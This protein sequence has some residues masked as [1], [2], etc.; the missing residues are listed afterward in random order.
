MMVKRTLGTGRWDKILKR[1]M[2]EL[3]DANNYNEAKEEWLATG[4]VWWAGNGEVPDWVSN[5]SNGIGNCLCGHNVVYH[6]EIVNTEN[7]VVECVG[8][9]HINSY[10]I[11]RQIAEDLNVE[12]DTITDA[13]VQEWIKVR[14]GS[15]KEE[16]WW[17]EN[18]DNFRLMFNKIKELDLHENVYLGDLYWSAKHSRHL[19]KKT[20]RKKGKGNFGSPTYRMASIVWRWNH[21]DN[22]KAQ[23]NTTGIPSDKVMQDLALL[24]VLSDAKIAVM[25][26]EKAEL[27]QAEAETTL[28][29]EREKEE[30]RIRR[31]ERAEKQRIADEKWESERPAREAARAI[32]AEK[33]RVIQEERKRITRNQNILFLHS[34][35]TEEFINKCG[36]YNIPVFGVDHAGND[37]EID[38]LVSI[39]RLFESKGTLSHNQAVSLRDIMN[40]APTEK[41]INYLRDLGYDG[42]IPTK[43]FASRKIKEIKENDEK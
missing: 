20:L 33:E 28:R 30:Y 23:T 17:A 24:F 36:L 18:G 11:M 25:E 10:L 32:R 22:P 9:D 42:E 27:K 38:F 2:V 8:S 43:L 7:G 15:M 14:V 41:Q 34:P 3:S 31:A 29:I 39:R 35:P 6:F 13:Q 21:P 19:P 4:Q 12:V 1:R 5:A 37:W 26:A 16:A 40:N